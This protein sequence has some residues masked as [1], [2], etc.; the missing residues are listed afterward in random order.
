MAAAELAALLAVFGTTVS[1]YLFF[2][3]TSEEVE[4]EHEHPE[5]V[6][7]T[8]RPIRYCATSTSR[9]MRVDVDRRDDV[10]GA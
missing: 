3:Q 8:H 5:P 4:E 7:T 9:A 1:P 2:W 10:G 6:P